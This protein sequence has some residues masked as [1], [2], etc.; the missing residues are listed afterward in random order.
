[1]S[2][3]YNQELLSSIRNEMTHLWGAIFVVGGGSI[4]LLMNGHTSIEFFFAIIG[5]ILTI[6]FVNAYFVRRNQVVQI[7]K[8]LEDK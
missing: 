2:D 6:M 3:L 5:I 8:S 7:V 1:M 4:V